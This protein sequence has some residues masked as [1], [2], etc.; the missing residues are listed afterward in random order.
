[1]LRMKR[2]SQRKP[3]GGNIQKVKMQIKFSIEEKL[4]N[5]VTG[6]TKG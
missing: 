6:K 4:I 3:E 2:Q 1:M 5:V